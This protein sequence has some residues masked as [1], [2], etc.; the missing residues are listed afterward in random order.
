MKIIFLINAVN[1]KVFSEK[2]AL[3]SVFMTEILITLT[4]NGG[5]SI[6]RILADIKEILRDIKQT[7]HN[8]V[9]HALFTKP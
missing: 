6:T 7:I 3:A 5:D 4:G 2:F 8:S 1:N 9:L